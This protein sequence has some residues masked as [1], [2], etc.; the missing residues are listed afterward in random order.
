MGPEVHYR[1]HH[2][3]LGAA[4]GVGHGRIGALKFHST[5]N[6]LA[7]EGLFR[8]QHLPRLGHDQLEARPRGLCAALML[9]DDEESQRGFASGRKCH[10]VVQVAMGAGDSMARRRSITAQHDGPAA[11]HRRIRGSEQTV[12]VLERVGPIGQA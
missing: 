7:V 3:G 4:E 2:V 1:H 9:T 5:E 8:S 12:P 10:T 6:P 11:R